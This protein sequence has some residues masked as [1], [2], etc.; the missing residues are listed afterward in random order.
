[1]SDSYCKQCRDSGRVEHSGMIIPCPLCMD[2]KNANTTTVISK[3]KLA[4][5]LAVEVA[6]KQ[7]QATIAEMGNVIGND[8]AQIKF[9]RDAVAD[10]EDEVARLL[11]VE[12]NANDLYIALDWVLKDYEG[13]CRKSFPPSANW[14]KRL[15][16]AKAALRFY[17]PA[18]NPIGDKP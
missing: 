11:A 6:I 9:Y 10:K 15:V 8:Q 7:L 12:S 5:L 3:A 16:T 1:M 2:R 14:K 13:M 18:I 4:H 17:K